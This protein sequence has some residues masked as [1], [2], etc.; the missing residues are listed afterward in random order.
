[1]KN[2]L[3]VIGIIAIVAIIGFGVVACGDGGSSSPPKKD[4]VAVTGVS[5]PPTLAVGID[6]TKNLTP[7]FTPSNATNKNVTWESD[8]E[9]VATVSSSGAVTGVSVGTA[10]ITVKTEDGGFEAECEVTVSE[11]APAGPELPVLFEGGEWAAV[12]GYVLVEWTGD[13]LEEPDSFS[14]TF[15]NAVDFSGYTKL[16]V[17][18]D[19]APGNQWW[20]GGQLANTVEE[21]T[22]GSWDNPGGAITVSGTTWTF[23]LEAV[24]PI[25]ED[26]DEIVF[27]TFATEPELI[28][29]HLE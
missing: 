9:D 11:D 29:M 1:M 23:D 5:L 3:K 12:L 6:Q 25:E 4:P 8:D 13:N 14:A 26:I 7:T 17:E 16:V 15:E 22:Y 19:Q 21:T 18:F 20:W 24:G 2:L 10:I 27:K 28:K